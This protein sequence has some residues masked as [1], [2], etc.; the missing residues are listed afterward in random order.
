MQQ[1]DDLKEKLSEQMK[2]AWSR[3]QELPLY[4]DLKERYD[5]LP[6]KSQKLVL[7]GGIAVALVILLSFPLGFLWT[8]SD[9]MR[10]FEEARE[11]TRELLEV[12]REAK[13]VAS[14][15]QPPSLMVL[16]T[17]V[18]GLLQRLQLSPEQILPLEDM[19]QVEPANVLP[20]GVQAQGIKVK[21]AKLNLR[22]VT[23]IGSQLESQL[24]TG[25][26]I[27]SFSMQKNSE[28]PE[29]FDVEYSLV[30][31]AMAGGAAGD[32]N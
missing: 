5:N 8:S 12:E 21:L 31:F 2:T 28:L 18:Q 16:R 15:P 29:Y 32:S 3:F 11:V 26:N 20:D 30:T 9:N 17:S 6:G 19:V 7:S 13:S 10:F 27:W 25:V 22:Q 24:Q 1:L 23:D 4:L 14:L